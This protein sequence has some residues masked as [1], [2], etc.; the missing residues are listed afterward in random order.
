MIITKQRFININKYALIAAMLVYLNG[1]FTSTKALQPGLIIVDWAHGQPRGDKI[2]G[3][4]VPKCGALEPAGLDKAFPMR[5]DR[6][7]SL[8]ARCGDDSG[9]NRLQ[10]R[11]RRRLLT[12][13]K[14]YGVRNR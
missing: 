5:A 8:F 10:P 11:S 14:M 13:V 6:E 3:P 4:I 2:T 9:K 7:G 12:P 1:V